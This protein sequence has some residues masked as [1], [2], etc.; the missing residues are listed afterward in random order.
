MLPA[1]S[2]L[3]PK[4]FQFNIDLDVWMISL[5]GDAP[6]FDHVYVI[7]NSSARTSFNSTFY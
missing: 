6:I 3:C 7:S 5:S 1:V 4:L 2:Q